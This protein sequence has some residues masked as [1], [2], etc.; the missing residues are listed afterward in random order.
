MCLRILKREEGL[1]R[2]SNR[3][4]SSMAV[5]FWAAL[6]ARAMRCDLSI[7][8]KGCGIASAAYLSIC[9][10]AVDSGFGFF[11]SFGSAYARLALSLSN[12]CLGIADGLLDAWLWNLGCKGK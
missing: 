2:R 12:P 4:A 10:I 5:N 7:K 8:N 9:A 6:F 3:L 11:S 1:I